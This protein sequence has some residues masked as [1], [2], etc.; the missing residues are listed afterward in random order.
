MIKDEPQP[1][2]TTP[3]K[4]V[5]NIISGGETHI[6][7]VFNVTIDVEV[8]AEL[9]NTG[10]SDAHN[11]RVDIQAQTASGKVI[12]IYDQGTYTVPV[13]DLAGKHTLEK[14]IKFP[15]TVSWGTGQDLQQNGIVFHINLVSNETQASLTYK[16]P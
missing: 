13:G 12:N 10:D 16:Y 15:M 5:L 7:G 8:H 4:L 2:A 11:I 9:T 6:I 1:T 14:D 3:P